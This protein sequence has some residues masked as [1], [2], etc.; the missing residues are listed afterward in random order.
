MR[1]ARVGSRP[2]TGDPG[3]QRGDQLRERAL[4]PIVEVPVAG[5]TRAAHEHPRQLVVGRTEEPL[6][7]GGSL[8]AAGPLEIVLPDAATIRGLVVS[9][10]DGSLVGDARLVQGGREIVRT[11]QDGTFEF[12]SERLSEER[13][14]FAA[15]GHA[16]TG[17]D[18][19]RDS[20]ARAGAPLVVRLRSTARLTVRVAADFGSR[21][22]R[23]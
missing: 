23:A 14:E 17:F 8:D 20:S 2:E 4:A 9:E 21:C 11:A 22:S 12:A 19:P 13:A 5:R 10:H 16:P 15:E 3:A 1:Q 6:A 18:A 7:P